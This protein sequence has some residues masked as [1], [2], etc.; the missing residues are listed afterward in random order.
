MI[1]GIVYSFT[2]CGGSIRVTFLLKEKN[3]VLDHTLNGIKYYHTLKTKL[4]RVS[5]LRY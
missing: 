1:S 3:P 2:L 5:C 4:L